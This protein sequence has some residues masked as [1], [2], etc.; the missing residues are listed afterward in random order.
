MSS[1]HFHPLRVASVEADTDEAVVVAFD[2]PAAL[3]D[4]FA[5]RPGQYL[6]LRA[7]VGGEDLRRSYSIC[8]GLQDGTLRVGVRKVAGGRFSGWV[9]DALKV[10]DELQVFPPQGHFVLPSADAANDA[11]PA[12]RHYLGIA[13]GSGITP[14]LAIMKTVL[15]SEP[16]SRFTLIYGNRSQ[17]ST[18]FKEEIEDLK[19]TFLTRLALHP[20]FSREQ[21]DAPLNAGRL[22]AGKLAQFLATLVDVT[23]VD[24]AFVCGPQGVIDAAEAVLT[25]AGLPAERLHIERFGAPDAAAAQAHP[26]LPGDAPQAVV[27]VVRDGLRRDV[28]FRTGMPSILDAIAAGGLEAPYSCKSGVCSTC[29][30]KVVEGQVRM[31]RNFALDKDE[32]AAGFVLCCQAH[33]LTERVVVTFDDR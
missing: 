29:R 11:A 14:I 5:F 9:N 1:L 4:T 28:E 7:D 20:V 32:V 15:A 31:D 17:K 30:A 3:R 13:A 24:H 22:D 10:G 16:A 18:M 2:V 25:S 19:N 8:S 12:G 27:T 33:P 21:I 26:V 23:D 6:T